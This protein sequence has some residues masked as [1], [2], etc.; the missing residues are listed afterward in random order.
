MYNSDL[1][2]YYVLSI[3][4]EIWN[5]NRS[6]PVGN[7]L[8]GKGKGTSRSGD[9]MREYRGDLFKVYYIRL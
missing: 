8:L 1:Q 4:Y 7:G 6:T 2:S 5:K 9:R 3:V